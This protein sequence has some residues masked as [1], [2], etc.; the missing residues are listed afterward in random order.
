MLP[1]PLSPLHAGG[2][3]MLLWMKTTEADWGQTPALRR[4][5]TRNESQT[6]SFGVPELEQS[7]AC[8]QWVSLHKILK[9]KHVLVQAWVGLPPVAWG[10]EVDSDSR[11]HGIG[12]KQLPEESR[13]RRLW[14]GKIAGM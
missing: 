9:R 14:L 11:T 2:E 13:E 3:Q 8:H 12:R 1:S 7:A 10:T 4:I 5:G 6:Q